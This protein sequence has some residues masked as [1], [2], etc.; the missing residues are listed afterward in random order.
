CKQDF[1]PEDT[2][3]ADSILETSF[4]KSSRKGWSTLTSFGL[5]ALAMAF[6][7]FLPLFRTEVL[8]FY[9]RI[10]TPVSL[11]RPIEARTARPPASSSASILQSNFVNQRLMM[12]TRIPTGVTN[13][14]EESL[15]QDLGTA[16][17]YVTEGSDI[18][19][20]DGIRN[21]ISE[22][23]PVV[24]APPPTVSRPIRIS[25]MSEGSLIHR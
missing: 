17:P 23:R 25:T 13:V 16:G 22:T 9:H 8:P 7:L 11:G 3:F 10:S 14:A 21:S 15:P 12:P 1:M 24:P 18:G 2:M 5:Q 20:P 4:G 19:L 6:L